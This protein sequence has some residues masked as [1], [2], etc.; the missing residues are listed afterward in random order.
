MRYMFINRSNQLRAG[1]DILLVVAEPFVS[2]LG[3]VYHFGRILARPYD[4][5]GIHMD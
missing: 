2:L 1:W 3:G 5:W 4:E